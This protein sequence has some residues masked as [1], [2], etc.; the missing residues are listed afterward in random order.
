[1]STVHSRA[2]PSE[3]VVA[4]H[5]RDFLAGVSP[6]VDDGDEMYRLFFYRHERDRE[7]ALVMYFASGRAIWE[8]IRTIASARFGDAAKIGRVLDVGS[9]HGRVTRFLSAA[10]GPGR[11]VAA[12]LVPE[13]LE[14]LRVELGVEAVGSDHDPSRFRPEGRF[15]LVVASSLF[16]HLPENRFG[17]WLGRLA[18]LL[19]E[20]G[21]LLASVHALDAGVDGAGSFRFEHESETPR[22]PLAEYGTSWVTEAKF[23]E[24]AARHAPGLDVVRIPG[25]FARTQDLFVVGRRLGDLET[26]GPLGDAVESH[27]E[28][29]APT[30][31]G[32]LSVAG[33]VVDR[34]SQRRPREIEVRLEGSESSRAATSNLEARAD[35][36]ALHGARDLARG[37]RLDCPLSA[38]A[39]MSDRVEI[40]ARLED[41]AAIRLAVGPLGEL[42]LRVLT[43][44]FS[45][46]AT[47]LANAEAE[48]EWMRS[49]RFWKL[50]D[51]WWRLR[52]KGT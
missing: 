15:D 26:S 42:A 30:V 31:H 48:I 22:L 19:T 32:T 4:E 11:V 16:T 49:S 38:S 21:L 41:G 3:L 44:R 29:F 17:A 43:Y 40:T 39:S 36:D 9:G 47:R 2:L 52:P 37:F 34:V 46:A 6:V 51:F 20:D 13:A 27:L 14:F 35:V 7:K 33:W 24:L 28:A 10:L 25:A 5:W 1:M 8:S 12:E 18:E 23:R 50:R 45:D